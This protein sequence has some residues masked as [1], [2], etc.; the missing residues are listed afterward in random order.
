M[1]ARDEIV[2]W[3]NSTSI[4]L[5]P[6][7]RADEPPGRRRRRGAQ[8]RLQRLRVPGL[9][10]RAAEAE[11]Q[12]VLVHH[13]LFWEKEPRVVEPV[14]RERL[15]ALRRRPEPRLH[16]LALDAH[17][18]VGNTR[19]SARNS[20]ST[21][22]GAS[23]T[24]SASAAASPSPAPVS[25]LAERV[26]QRLGRMPLY[27]F[28]DPEVVERVAVSPA[29]P[30]YLAQAAAEHN[31]FVTGEADEPT[32]QCRGSGIAFIAG[33]LPPRR[34]LGVRALSEKL[35]SASTSPGTSSQPNPV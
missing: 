31:C 32:K 18:E 12:L 21:A 24:V 10:E 25:K 17:P 14:M 33:G 16:H 22:R 27:V 26:Q 6:R 2:S 11:A 5:L 15:R 30:L 7:L 23:P 20:G 35:A 8:D 13:G 29:L 3:A 28:S 4:S 9:F 1:P 34:T 19:S